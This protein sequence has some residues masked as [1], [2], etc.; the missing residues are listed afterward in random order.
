M[1]A[2]VP[3]W[4][5]A[6]AEPWARLR[7]ESWA[8]PKWS[9]LALI[10]AVVW[11][12]VVEPEAPCSE[13]A[14]CGPD[15]GGM[16]QMGLAVGLLYWFA[17]LPELALITAPVLAV[18]VARWELSGVGWVSRVA[19]LAVIAALAFGWAAAWSRLAMRRGQRQMAERSAGMR[20]HLPEPVGPLVRGSIPIVGALILCAVAIG[21]VAMGLRGIRADE[22][23]ADRAVRTTGRVIGQGEESVRLR[24]ADEH[25]VVVSAAFPEDY[26]IGG[27]VT[28]LEDGSWRRLA[29]E[30]YDAF[31]WQLLTLV[32]VL[33]GLSLLTV[34]I[35]ARG[36]AAALRRAPVPVLRVLESSVRDVGTLVY[37]ADD[38][39]G[40]TPLLE[41]YCVPVLPEGEI[42]EAAEDEAEGVFDDESPDSDERLHEAVMFGTPYEGGELVLVT[43][44]GEGNPL[45]IRTASPVRLPQ[46]DKGPA[47]EG[48]AI[49]DA[50]SD[51]AAKALRQARAEQIA[52]GLDP[53]GVP[54]HWGP[55]A[56]ARAGGLVFAAGIV[57][58]CWFFV[59]TLVTE[60]FS[61]NVVPLL[62]LLLAIGPAATL[63][64][65]RATV[66]STG[67]WLTRAW[68]VRHVPWE[69]LRSV[70]YTEEGNVEI[71][72]SGG[73]IW[74]LTALGWPWAERRL[75]IRPSYVRM[76]EEITALRDHPELRPAEPSRPGNQGRPLAPF[77]LLLVGLAALVAIWR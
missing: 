11:A 6:D 46:P 67:L 66:D 71:R 62:G 34:G 17:K 9:V 20:H 29:A 74:Q 30:P 77:L 70:E 32:A 68:K 42:S 7:P 16:V 35:L 21:F 57:A 1:P 60:G 19:N 13:M 24:T 31:G 44:D 55:G 72:L 14:P 28:V 23:H 50:A 75:R 53:T 48:A 12:I 65:W 5:T 69:R 59:R 47:A 36:R 56:M 26:R 18:I 22:D 73:D 25:R 51:C 54:M 4:L 37:A 63:L 58:A 27:T 40:R 33:P 45:V 15:W 2:G 61:W 49:T 41:C 38:T 43:T 64:N 3:G 76:A 10:V 39:A 52:E 8:R